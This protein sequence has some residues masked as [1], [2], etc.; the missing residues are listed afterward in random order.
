MEKRDK[1]TVL[2]FKKLTR[3]RE[4]KKTL[5]KGTPKEKRRYE[6]TSLS[7]DILCPFRRARAAVEHAQKGASPLL[8][9]F[10]KFPVVNTFAC[11]L[12]ELKSK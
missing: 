4:K 6:V 7:T 2:L 3:E 1:L 9:S 11:H 10:F 12:D 8:L 5:L